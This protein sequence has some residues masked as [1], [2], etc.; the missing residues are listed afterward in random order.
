MR[1][2][3]FEIRTLIGRV[4]PAGAVLQDGTR[5]GDL[6]LCNAALPIVVLDRDRRQPERWWHIADQPVWDELFS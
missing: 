5:V 6:N 2:V 4:R 3:T 1:P